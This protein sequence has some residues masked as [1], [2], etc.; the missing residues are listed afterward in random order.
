M[1]SEVLQQYFSDKK[2]SGEGIT[3]P[4]YRTTQDIIDELAPMM[5]MEEDDILSYMLN[6]DYL[7]ITD[8]DGSVK[9]EMYREVPPDA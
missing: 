5:K 6:R 7:M 1:K 2:T 4:C 9:W 3:V 8:I